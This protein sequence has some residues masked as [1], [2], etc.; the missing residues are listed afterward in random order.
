MGKEGE[1]E[2]RGLV[3]QEGIGRWGRREGEGDGV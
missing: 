3:V 2:R 1:R